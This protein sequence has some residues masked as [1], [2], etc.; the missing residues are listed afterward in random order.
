MV[1]QGPAGGGAPGLIPAGRAVLMLADNSSRYGA[2]EEPLGEQRPGR[3]SGAE[4]ERLTFRRKPTALEMEDDEG[5][6]HWNCPFPP[7]LS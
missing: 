4:V 7:H 3:R 5:V 1:D 2:R 6:V